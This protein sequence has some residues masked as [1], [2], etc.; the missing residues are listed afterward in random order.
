MCPDIIT[1][2]LEN[3]IMH[4]NWLGS[5][6]VLDRFRINIRQVQNQ[7]SWVHTKSLNL[8]GAIFIAARMRGT[9]MVPDTGDREAMLRDLP[10]QGLR[11][12]WPCCAGNKVWERC[13][14]SKETQRGHF[15]ILAAM[16]SPTFNWLFLAH[17]LIAGE[18]MERHDEVMRCYVA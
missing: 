4:W 9:W 7:F 6:P 18:M 5:E 1:R 12:L 2:L 10:M 15:Q 16:R 11:W 8:R 13:S 3:W 17:F 14:G